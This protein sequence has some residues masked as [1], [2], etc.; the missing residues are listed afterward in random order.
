MPIAEAKGDDTG[1]L[2]RSDDA[3]AHFAKVNDAAEI[4]QRGDDLISLAVDPSNPNVVYLTNTSTY[5]S[6]D[7][8]K[9]LVAIKGAPG[10]RRLS[11]GLDQSARILESLR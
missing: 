7:G 4:A 2:Y 9:R 11:H 10:R 6:T 5:R 8:G 3:G 1:A